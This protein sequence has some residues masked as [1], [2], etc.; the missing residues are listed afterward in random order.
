[1]IG[2][3]RPSYFLGHGVLGNGILGRGV[4]GRGTLGQ[5]L[6]L[7]PTLISAGLQAGASIYSSH[8]QQTIARMQKRTAEEIQR[9]QD[10]RAAAEAKA[11]ADAAAG[12]AGVT[13]APG[14]PG[15]PGATSKILG[16][17]QGVFIA[18]G[19]GLALMLGVVAIVASKSSSKS[20]E[21]V[22]NAA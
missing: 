1:M 8:M 2:L 22:R 20:A 15:A 11:A 19:V 4:L 21:P 14:T 3:G 16:I 12:A 13:G 7:I 10:A 17:D 18:G 9:R 6:D 5:G